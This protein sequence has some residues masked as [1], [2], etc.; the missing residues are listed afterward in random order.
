MAFVN[1]WLWNFGDGET[2]TEQ[3]PTHIYTMAGVYVYTLTRAFNTG[4][5]RIDSG[6]IYVYNY[7]LSGNKP[8]ASI[9][10]KC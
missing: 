5:V 10:N 8:N 7:D 2:S 6:T 1:S 9:T 4:L 3:S